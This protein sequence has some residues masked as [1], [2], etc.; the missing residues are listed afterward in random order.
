[1]T[2]LSPHSEYP[3]FSF[4]R[5]GDER[6][7]QA[8]RASSLRAFNPVAQYGLRLWASPG[9]HRM[10]QVSRSADTRHITVLT[11]IRL[12]AA[13]IQRWRERTRSR[14]QLRELSDHMLRDIGLRR[15]DLGYEFPKPFWLD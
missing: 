15:E 14:Q 12:T 6:R 3:H 13:A 1:M 10:A 5:R 4:D 11:A 8:V 9:V 2:Q 7:G